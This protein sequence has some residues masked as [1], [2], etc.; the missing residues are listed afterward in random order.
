MRSRGDEKRVMRRA[1]RLW[2]LKHLLRVYRQVSKE[3]DAQV[4]T[5]FKYMVR[6]SE[7]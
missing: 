2:L 7:I 3:K 5:K 6:V 1:I 4:E